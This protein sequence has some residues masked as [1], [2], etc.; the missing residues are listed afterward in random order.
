MG[1]ILALFLAQKEATKDF[2][3]WLPDGE[4]LGGSKN[5]NR[6]KSKEAPVGIQGERGTQS[7][8][9]RDWDSLQVCPPPTSHVTLGHISSAHRLRAYQ[10]LQV[11]VG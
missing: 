2:S 1:R 11:S 7:V 4:W 9:R 10:S 8:P 6:G 3:L 5:G